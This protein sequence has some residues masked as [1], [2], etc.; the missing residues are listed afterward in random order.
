MTKAKE[1]VST[2][3][4]YLQPKRALPVINPQHNTQHHHKEGCYLSPSIFY[5]YLLVTFTSGK[6]NMMTIQTKR[7]SGIVNK[8]FMISYMFSRYFCIISAK[9]LKLHKARTHNS[10]WG[11]AFAY[12]VQG[13][14]GSHTVFEVQR[15][16]FN[17]IICKHKFKFYLYHSTPNTVKFFVLSQL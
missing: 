17:S 14:N 15:C 16:Y 5:Y 7:K 4:L 6:T 2:F 11:G 3:N 9:V 13:G 12:A 10:S 1:E 8:L